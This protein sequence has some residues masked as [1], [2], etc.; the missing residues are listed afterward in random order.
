MAIETF[1]IPLAYVIVAALV[2]WMAITARGLWWVKALVILLA[3]LFSIGLWR[4]LEGLQG[5][6]VEAEM[7]E[8]FEIKWTLVDEPNKKTGSPGAVYVWARNLSA[9]D[10]GRK[11]FALRLQTRDLGR[12]PRIFKLP[13]S[14][15]L[16]EQTEE[17]QVRLMDGG[18]FFGFLG[19]AG[20]EEGAPGGPGGR[21]G[22]G[23]GRS[24]VPGGEFGLERGSG[25]EPTRQEYIFHEL[26]PP[27]F[28]AKTPPG[29]RA[30]EEPR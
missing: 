24:P 5:W 11:P 16:H 12:E 21:G 29:Q 7:P 13:Y 19:R 3:V 15:P 8:R 22:R 23:G 10:P 25:G 2:L 14:R 9:P 6:P 18:R 17:I 26:P 30:D 1:G 4:S 27:S 20:L 28:P